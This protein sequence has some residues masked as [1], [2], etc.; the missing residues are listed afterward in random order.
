[1]INEEL[2]PK[3]RFS[4][5]SKGWS[6]RAISDFGSVVTGST[7]ST[8]TQEFYGGNINFISPAD[9]QGQRYVNSTKTT[10]TKAGFNKCRK[11]PP[12]SILFVCIGSS[13]GKV[14]QTPLESCSNQ[15]INAV[16]VNEENSSDFIFSLLEERSARIAILAGEQAVPIINKSQF[17]SVKVIAPDCKKE[18]QKIADF[19][20][21]V[22]K[23]TFLL[24]EKYALLEQYKK[25][26]MQKL[27]SRETRFKDEND[28]DFPDWQEE[29]FSNIL[30]LQLNSLQMNDESEYELITVRRR[31]GGVD[32]RGIYKGKEVLVKNQYELK[33][34]QFV[35]SKRQ[36]VHGACGLVPEAL[37]GAIVSNEYNVFEPV[38]EKLDINYFNMIATS[39]PMRRAFF[40]NSDGVH[41][42]KLL[43]KTQSWLKT[44]L[45]FPCVEEQRK[46]VTFINSL[47]KKL[48]L[49]S[50]QIE[51]TQTFKKGLLQQMFV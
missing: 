40:I 7:P 32:S 46:I 30:Q 51:Q 47:D 3:L 18:Q 22:D 12:S 31:N 1:M 4:E 41:I 39:L 2:Q 21:A 33:T 25:G 37:A 15:Q 38:A 26:V 14:A 27:F 17:S 35:I 34:N 42:E 20:S 48:E 28:N 10:L 49:V 16:V 9:M 19:L 36:I 8:A 5:F 24:K 44:K 11:L 6:Y 29:R 45:D 50:Q 43:F 23:K 13:I